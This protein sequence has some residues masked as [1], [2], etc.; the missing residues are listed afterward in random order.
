VASEVRGLAQRTSGAA[1]EIKLLIQASS[2]TVE[3]G[4][5][6]TDDAQKTMAHALESVRQVS[7]VIGEISTGA[8]EQLMGISQVNEAVSQMDTITQQNAALVEQMAASAVQLQELT[9][10][11]AAAVQV[12]KLDGSQRAPADAIALRRQGRD[13]LLTT[14]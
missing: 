5:R 2:D 13:A 8:Q 1:R 4:H 12:F 14:P 3:T 11:V 9:A 6:L 7:Q 10:S